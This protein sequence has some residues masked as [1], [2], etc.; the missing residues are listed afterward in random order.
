[1]RLPRERLLDMRCM[2]LKA[3]TLSLGGVVTDGAPPKA[4]LCDLSNYSYER[5]LASPPAFHLLATTVDVDVSEDLLEWLAPSCTQLVEL[6]SRL[7]SARTPPTF[8]DILEAWSATA[9]SL[10]FRRTYEVET[11]FQEGLVRAVEQC[12]RLHTLQY[13]GPP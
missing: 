7:T 1:M 10:T 11:T 6:D 9:S 3:F 4:N 8:L 2:R 12:T 5:L 13:Y